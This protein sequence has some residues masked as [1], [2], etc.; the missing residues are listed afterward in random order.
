MVSVVLVSCG[1]PTTAKLPTYTSE[2]I[3]QIQPLAASVVALRD[4]M[5]VLSDKIK[6]RNWTDV[7]TYIHGPMGELRRSVS[8]LTRELLPQE[9]QNAQEVAKDL[10]DNMQ[11]I[12]VA[13]AKGNYELAVKSYNAALKDFDALLRLVPQPKESA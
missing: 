9:Q 2:Q 1:S 7:V 11:N 5:D 10:F 13:S 6:N 4:R 8:Y 3:A 12:D